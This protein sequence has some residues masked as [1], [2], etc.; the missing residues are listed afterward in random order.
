[1][2]ECVFRE[3]FRITVITVLLFTLNKKLLPFAIVCTVLFQGY[4]CCNCICTSM[5]KVLLFLLAYAA[6]VWEC[7]NYGKKNKNICQEF[8]LLLF[9]YSFFAS[10]HD[11][12]FNTY[13]LCSLKDK[14]KLGQLLSHY[15]LCNVKYITESN[16]KYSK[17]FTEGQFHE[18]FI[19]T[20]KR[21]E[22]WN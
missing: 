21:F 2:C 7:V 4:A 10:L 15:E 16:W 13:V 17:Y 9:L 19:N 3:L 14:R 20:H 18:N 1:M 11:L 5:H 22:K 12:E 6:S 8:G